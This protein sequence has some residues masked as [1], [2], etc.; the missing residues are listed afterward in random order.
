MPEIRNQSTTPVGILIDQL[1]I[2]VH[3]ARTKGLKL[4]EEKLELWIR[5]RP[6]F[7]PKCIWYRLIK[8]VLI[9]EVR[10]V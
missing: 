9:Q 4:W 10:H 6:R 1:S 2:E 7:V 8:I 3:A 5:P